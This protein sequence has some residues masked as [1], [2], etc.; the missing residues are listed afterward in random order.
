[1][2]E[3]RSGIARAPEWLRWSAG[4]WDSSVPFLATGAAAIVAGGL[5]AAVSGPFGLDNGSWLAA[6][7]VLVAGV[8]QIVLGCGQAAIA[9]AE[10]PRRLVVAQFLAWNLAAAAVVLGTFL[11]V[12]PL[13]SAGGA[14][15][16]LTLAMLLRGTLPARDGARALAAAYR[17]LVL[18]V[19]VS[20]P[21]GLLLAWIRRA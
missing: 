5:V 1:M 6:Y 18:V 4:R 16:V 19:L 7:L 15:T 14:M 8:A 2:G 10:P 3:A 17:S 21:I 20:T 12:P 9:A 11:A 13:T